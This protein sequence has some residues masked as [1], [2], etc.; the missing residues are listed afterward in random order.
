MRTGQIEVLQSLGYPVYARTSMLEAW[1]KEQQAAAQPGRQATVE[2]VRA[3][4]IK[5]SQKTRMPSEVDKPR[6]EAQ[7]QR[8]SIGLLA[9]DEA[10]AVF[11]CNRNEPGMHRSLIENMLRKCGCNLKELPFAHFVWPVV[12]NPRVKQGDEEAARALAAMQAKLIDTQDA[13]VVVAGESARRSFD[14]AP[15]GE[16]VIYL[17][18]GAAQ[19]IEQPELR[20][21]AWE[22]LLPLR[23]QIVGK[24][25]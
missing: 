23:D 7:W 8:L 22:A 10:L 20:K 24:S 13:W 18:N 4:A 3:R 2:E 15:F 5:V 19:M 17:P 1:A 12:E 21:K 25:G 14:P 11:D 16:K 6:M 9:S